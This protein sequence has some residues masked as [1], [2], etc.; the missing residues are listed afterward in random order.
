MSHLP[1][2]TVSADKFHDFEMLID[3]LI[4]VS[5]VSFYEVFVIKGSRCFEPI[6]RN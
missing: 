2:P 6:I 5:G 4:C 1:I 3:F